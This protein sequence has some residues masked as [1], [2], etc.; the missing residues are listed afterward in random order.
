MASLVSGC[1]KEI[2]PT[3][4]QRTN[5]E[6]ELELRVDVDGERPMN[7]V[8]GDI[9]LNIGRIRKYLSSFRF[10]EIKKVQAQKNEVMLTCEHGNFA[11]KSE[12][13][14]QFRIKIAQNSS[15]LI[16]N[17]NW[18]NSAGTELT[19]LC[20]YK[21]AYFRRAQVENDY[22][23]GV[24]P[25]KSYNTSA[26]LSKVPSYP[27]PTTLTDAYAKAGIKIIMTRKGTNPVPHPKAIQGRGAVWTE[28]ALNAAMTEH[29]SM[30][31]DLPQ[32][33]VWLFSAYDYQ[34][35]GVKGIMLSHGGK[36]RRGCAVFHRATGEESNEEK[37]WQL[38]IYVHELGHCFNLTHPW[39]KDRANY[40]TGE[41]GYASLSWMT[42]PWRYYLSKSSY[43]E[44]AFWK[45]FQ[46]Q[47]SNSELFHLRHAFR[48]DIIFGGNNFGERNTLEPL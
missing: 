32:W 26:L 25:F 34:V 6:T 14:T 16:A 38:F 3:P 11:P 7:V 42:I 8:S 45:N 21:S 4:F 48:N 47:F 9:F 44:E 12:E 40:D 37:R 18:I 19:S 23:E 20:K 33:K 13:L 39:D 46:F 35:S 30:L 22:E 1:Y 2:Y 36:N 27:L 43:G 10:V 15:P 31:K 29:F 5:K 17:V 24:L 28:N 41:E